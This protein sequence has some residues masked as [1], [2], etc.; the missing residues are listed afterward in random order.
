MVLG[1]NSNVY[2]LAQMTMNNTYVRGKGGYIRGMTLKLSGCVRVM[3]LHMC[4][5]LHDS[6]TESLRENPFEGGSQFNHDQHLFKF[7]HKLYSV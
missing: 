6:L 3:Y 2:I 7:S 4:A 5:K 1:L